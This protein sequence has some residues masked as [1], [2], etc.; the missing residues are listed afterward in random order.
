MLGQTAMIYMSDVM[1]FGKVLLGIFLLL[2][3]ASYLFSK[4][5]VPI[6]VLFTT[7][8]S[9]AAAFALLVVLVLMPGIKSDEVALGKR[10]LEEC[11]LVEKFERHT[12]REPTNR[13]QC[14]GVEEQ[15]DA[16]DYQTFTVAY[17][18]REDRDPR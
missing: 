9:A 13:L 6:S 16:S 17:L 15:V 3:L 12:L 10:W 2:L 4:L 18:E 8:L 1:I 7:W 14:H 5:N 11:T